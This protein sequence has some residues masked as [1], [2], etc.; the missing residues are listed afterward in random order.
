MF[1]VTLVPFDFS[2]NF[3]STIFSF[4]CTSVKYR[5]IV[6]LIS[7]VL[8]LLRAV[9]YDRLTVKKS[10]MRCHEKEQVWGKLNCVIFYISVS[11][12]C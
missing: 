5:A 8:L 12:C 10:V 3:Q 7:V 1:Q 11:C 2:F 4:T 9:P 6:S